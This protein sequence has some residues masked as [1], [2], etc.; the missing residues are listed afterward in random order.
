M[1]RGT[2][3]PL[4]EE[5]RS[6]RAGRIIAER[7]LKP[8]RVFAGPLLR[9]R[10]TAELILSRLNLASELVISPILAE[11]DYGPDENRTEP[12][13]ADRLG[14]LY[15]ARE[16]RLESAAAEEI[17][18]RGREVIALWDARAI[19]PAGWLVEPERI[20]SDLRKFAAGIEEGETVLA[21]SSNGVIRFAPYLLPPEKTRAFMAGH[22]LKV[23]TGGVCLLEHSAGQWRITAWNLKA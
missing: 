3:L 20:I 10:Q 6:L 2:D 17:D 4:V 5:E 19:P 22:N 18:R 14:R 13:V 21:V 1:G 16:G 15:L 12:E 23:S 7:G 8:H 9:T 11:I